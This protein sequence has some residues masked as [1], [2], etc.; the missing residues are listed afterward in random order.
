MRPFPPLV[1]I[2]VVLGAAF[3]VHCGRH[4]EALP[5]APFPSYDAG[6]AS[7]GDG[8]GSST[9][10]DG[11]GMHDDFPA[12]PH[13]DPSLPV[14]TGIRFGTAAAT[15]DAGG[16]A[17]LVAP[18]VTE[19]QDDAMVPRNWTPIFVEWSSPDTQVVTEITMAVDNQAHAYVAY[20][21]GRTFTMPQAT[22][23]ALAAHSAGHDVTLTVRTAAMAANGALAPASPAAR[24]TLHIAPVDAAGSVVY[25]SASPPTSFKG[26]AIGDAVSKTV[27]TP[28]SAGASAGGATTCIGCHTASVDGKLIFYTRDG[29]DTSRAIDVRQVASAAPPSVG[30]VS[31]AAMALLARDKQYAPQVSA[32]HYA[33]NDAVALTVFR[34]GTVNELIWTDLHAADGNGWGQLART[35]DTRNVSS[36]AWRHDGSAIAYTSSAGGGE[37]VIA[38]VTPTDTTMAIYTVPYNSRQGGAATPLPGASD[39]AY[40]QF[41]PTYSPGDALLAFSRTASAVSSYNQ[42]TAEIAIVPGG[43]GVATRLR[44]NDPAIC[45]GKVSPGLTNSWPRWAPKVGTS[46]DLRYYWL[47]FS[48][49]RRGATAGRPQLFISCIVTRVA[50]GVESLF[51]EHPAVYVTSQDAAANNHIPAWDAFDVA[52]IPK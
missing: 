37:G 15:S 39:A 47:V 16:S 48:S 23:S 50:Q 3:A 4:D 7:M 13:V 46:G 27:L 12:M 14:G 18:C 2:A 40:R 25:W 34:I 19:P 5:G 33:P 6:G 10:D 24:S 26:F 20:V 44:A 52:T 17:P 31:P 11:T 35:G 21:P 9:L 32:A 43:G 30:D 42:P 36:P 38:A 28:A 29:A 41:Y 51:A 1:L 49:T 22:W 45:D 8:G